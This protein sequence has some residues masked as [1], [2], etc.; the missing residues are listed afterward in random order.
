M[1][2][3]EVV[4]QG[5][6]AQLAQQRVRFP[7]WLPQ[8]A[9]EPARVVEA[10]NLSGSTGGGREPD[11]DVV[12]RAHGR[13]RRHHA[14]APRHPQVQQRAA[15]LRIEQQVFRATTHGVDALPGQRARHLRR[16]RPA[17]VGAAQQHVGDDAAGDVRGK[18][19]AGGFDLGQF[20]HGGVCCSAFRRGNG[21][22]EIVRTIA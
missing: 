16:N 5:F 22:L 13:I 19:R 14:Q 7:A 10:Q 2:A 1:V 8:Q 17:Q 4:R 18:P 15:R 9:A 3:V 20:R 6:G 11:V 12:V 21:A